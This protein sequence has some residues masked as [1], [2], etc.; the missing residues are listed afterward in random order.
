[1]IINSEKNTISERDFEPRFDSILCK[2]FQLF[3]RT[4]VIGGQFH[5]IT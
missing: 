3:C 1:M 5:E 4:I 2:S